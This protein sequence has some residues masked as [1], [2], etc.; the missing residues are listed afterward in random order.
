MSETLYVIF[1]SL[2]KVFDTSISTSVTDIKKELQTDKTNF[3]NDVADGS[4]SEP[5]GANVQTAQTDIS[6]AKS[7]GTMPTGAN[8]QTVQTDISNAKSSG[9][10]PTGVRVQEVKTDIYLS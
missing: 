2:M 4:I 3:N 9:T 8:V 6:N 1:L 7:S 5:T 10:M